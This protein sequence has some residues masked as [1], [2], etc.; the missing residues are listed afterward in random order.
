MARVTNKYN[1]FISNHIA[2]SPPV[3]QC[4]QFTLLRTATG[5]LFI[6]WSGGK[7]QV[8]RQ[9]TGLTILV[10]RGGYR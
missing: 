2:Q 1:L 7:K 4:E 5:R 10:A 6:Y 8:A 9:A 3:G